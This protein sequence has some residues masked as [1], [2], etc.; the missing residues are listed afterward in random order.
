MSKR[1]EHT[2]QQIEK[3]DAILHA[4]AEEYIK[5]HGGHGSRE[6]VESVGQSYVAAMNKLEFA[7]QQAPQE[8][9]TAREKLINASEQLYE[10]ARLFSC[11]ATIILPELPEDYAMLF[12]EAVVMRKNISL[13]EIVSE[14]EQIRADARIAYLQWLDCP[15]SLERRAMRII[16]PFLG[17]AQETIDKLT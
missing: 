3:A 11:V 17:Q 4:Q 14:A 1:P 13:E 9:L 16:Q 10:K 7:I 5:A 8:V 12:F 2:D 6:P 15:S